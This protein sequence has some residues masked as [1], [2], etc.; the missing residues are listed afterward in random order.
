[1]P[2]V[3]ISKPDKVIVEHGGALLE[4]YYY[5]ATITKWQLDGKDILFTSS[6]AILDG[7]KAIRG[8][9]PLV[10]PQ[11]GSK[12]DGYPNA[13][14]QHGFARVSRWDW[15]GVTV[16]NTTET[17]IAFSLKPDAIPKSH[18]DKWGFGEFTSHTISKS[19]LN[20]V[21]K[22]FK[23]IYS[24]TLMGSSLKTSL[25]VK[26]IGNTP[27]PF[28]TLLHTYIR[29]DD[30]DKVRVSGLTGY[31]YVD[32]VAIAPNG[33]PLRVDEEE[34]VFVTITQEVDRVYERVKND[35]L[36]VSNVVIHKNGFNDVVVWNPWIDRAK[37]L[38]DFA[39]DEYKQMICVEVGNVQNPIVLAP[40][41][42][43]KGSQVLTA[44]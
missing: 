17:T 9:I 8:G 30:V 28:E 34:N 36:T 13:L 32:K 26:N 23:L 18:R 14:P 19:F 41:D 11:F 7:S 22:D 38:A 29:I 16:L 42:E 24:V 10:F 37:A 12:P 1:M 25:T 27:F 6:K 39:D 35:H 43:W 2:K 21:S 15:V 33:N 3:D 31:P 4:V 40:G 44:I 20:L 5:G